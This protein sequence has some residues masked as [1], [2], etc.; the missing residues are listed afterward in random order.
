MGKKQRHH[1][2][3][4]KIPIIFGILDINIEDITSVVK[5]LNYNS[6]IR[7]HVDCT[8][9]SILRR[10]IF[11]HRKPRRNKKRISLPV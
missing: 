11:E 4:K 1:W 2:I 10:N 3:R 5:Q 8:A 6:E 9:K 7:N